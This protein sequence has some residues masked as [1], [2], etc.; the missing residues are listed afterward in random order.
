VAAVKTR[1][2]RIVEVGIPTF[3]LCVSTLICEP[4]AQP[5]ADCAT[6]STDTWGSD[7][8]RKSFGSAPVAGSGPIGMCEVQDRAGR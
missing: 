8:F 1:S 4:L 3:L 2:G 5:P 7:G 6:G